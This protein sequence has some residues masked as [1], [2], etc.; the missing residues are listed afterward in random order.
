M[1]EHDNATRYP[2]AWPATWPRTHAAN[3][4]RATFSK[5]ITETQT[6]RDAQGRDVHERKRRT[7]DLSSADAA[8]RLEDQIER[9]GGTGP[10]LSTNQ[11]L[12]MD[13]RPKQNEGEPAD[14]GAAVYF[15]LKGKPR[16]LACDKWDRVADNVAALAA[17]IDALR[18]ID[19]YGVGTLDQAFAGYT[20][21]PPASTDWRAVFEFNG[22][23]PTFAD[24]DS[25]YRA[26]AAVHH[27][28][29][30]G[31]PQMMARIN[32]ARDAARNE[33]KP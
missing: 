29:R 13:G 26:L 15:R 30:G 25:K 12:R 7:L 27:P 18:R 1:S 16:C 31:D 17:H 23:S 14:V 10:I 32:M 11:R 5:S 20:A 21:L 28:D 4:Q 33:L 8:A 9:L 19:R 24:V 6:T 2:L 22:G 3:R